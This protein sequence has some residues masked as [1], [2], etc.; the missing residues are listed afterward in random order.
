[1]ARPGLTQTIMEKLEGDLP[2]GYSW[3]GAVR[4][5]EQAV[6]RILLTGKYGGDSFISGL[7]PEEN[8]I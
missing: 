3:P 4:E 5:L 2:P 6:R 1:M 7:N 8:F